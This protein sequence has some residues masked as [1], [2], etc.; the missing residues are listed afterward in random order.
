MQGFGQRVTETLRL[1][2]WQQED[3]RRR[4]RVDKAT[5]SRWCSGNPPGTDRLVQL[6]AVL[7]VSVHWLLTGKGERH[8]DAD[9]ATDALEKIRQIADAALRGDAPVAESPAALVAD[10]ETA[11]QALERHREANTRRK[12]SG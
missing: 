5:V 10:A 3:L 6:A 12:G 9:H 11:T 8:P 4:M 2:D 7:G 1:R